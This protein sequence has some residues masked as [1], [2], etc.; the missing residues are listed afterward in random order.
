M[1]PEVQTRRPRSLKKMLIIAVVC[2]LA[3]AGGVFAAVA[4][5]LAGG[6]LESEAGSATRTSPG[7]ASPVVAAV[8]SEASPANGAKQVN[9]AAPVSLKVS[10]GTIERVAL[11]STAGEKVDGSIDP[12]G[13]GWTATAPL[14][15]NTD[16]S[17]TFVV[18][19]EAGRETSTT[20]QFSTVSSSH[21]A[22]AA[23]YPLDGM[24]VGVGQPLQIIFS[25]PVLNRDS[26]EKAIKVTSSA[27]QVGAFHWYSDKMV[28]YRAENFWAANSTVTMDMQ[29]FGV[30]LGNGQIAN[31]DKKVKVNIGDKKVAVADATAHT[32]TLSVN[33]QPVKT[34]PVSM[35]DKRFPS[36]RGY[37]VL[38]EKNRFDHF[39]ASSIGL[40]PGDPAYYGDVDVEYTIRLTLSGAYIHQALESAFPYIGNTNVSHGCIG[41]APDGA[42]WVF[43]NM[44]TGDVVN[45]I[46]TEGDYAAHDDGYGDWNIPWAEYDN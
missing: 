14:K 40:K 20:Q 34:L 8:K 1:E 10:N 41:F 12:A 16:Y 17:Y 6:D 44:G 19:D 35:G 7:I 15:F 37:G 26:V 38:M 42:A 28:R 11:T 36:A 29:M 32:F 45:I 33:D 5:G 39:R 25:E 3:A 46:N 27:G 43:D 22:D 18:K 24:K 30:D 13:T 4:P 9:P 31:F 23:V 21:E 2:I